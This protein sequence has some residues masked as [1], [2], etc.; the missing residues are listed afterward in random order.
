MLHQIEKEE[1]KNLYKGSDKSLVSGRPLPVDAMPVVEA[2]AWGKG[3]GE[4]VLSLKTFV[5]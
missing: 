5:C 3:G 4:A 1:E 2:G